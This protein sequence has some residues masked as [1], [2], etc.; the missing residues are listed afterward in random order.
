MYFYMLCS[1]IC[2]LTF[3]SLIIQSDLLNV[4]IFLSLFDNYIPNNNNQIQRFFNS[5]IREGGG[6]Y[7]SVQDD[8]S[9]H[10]KKF[11]YKQEPAEV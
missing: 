8:V 9:H 5:S 2:S 6:Y 4:N 1:H 11:L 7:G 10:G 3:Y